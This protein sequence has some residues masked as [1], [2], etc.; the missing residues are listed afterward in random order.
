MKYELPA[1]ATWNN[2][3]TPNS[4]NVNP[5]PTKFYINLFPKLPNHALH[6]LMAPTL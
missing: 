5:P 4:Q 2:Y 1:W 3:S 6:P